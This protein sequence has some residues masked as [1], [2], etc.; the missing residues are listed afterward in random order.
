[1]ICTIVGKSVTEINFCTSRTTFEPMG[2]SEIHSMHF[3]FLK[4]TALI[5]TPFDL[6]HWFI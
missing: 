5:D 4:F 2:T 6:N 3:I 1:M